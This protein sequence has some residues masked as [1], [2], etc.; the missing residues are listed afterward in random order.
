MCSSWRR[1]AKLIARLNCWQ[2]L[3]AGTPRQAAQELPE[4]DAL[5][6]EDSEQEE[7]AEDGVFRSPAGKPKAGGSKG[8]SAEAVDRCARQAGQSVPCKADAG[9]LEW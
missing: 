8:T 3:P 1:L 4:V 2:A 7:G 6:A 9:L 5:H